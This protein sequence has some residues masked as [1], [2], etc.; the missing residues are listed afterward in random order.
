MFTSVGSWRGPF[1]PVE[2]EGR[3]FGLRVHEFRRFTELPALVDAPFEIALDIEPEDDAD[4]R[5]LRE[6]SWGIADP[7]L[8]AADLPSYQRY[9]RESMAEI[10]V[11]KEMYVATRGGWFSDRSASY[12]ASGK[13][14]LAQDTGF[15]DSLPT[16]DGLLAF[17][18]LEQ[19]VRGAE[20]ITVDLGHH[21]EAARSIA[22]EFF[23]SR[24]V[25]A[26]LLEDLDAR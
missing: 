17:S 15:G 4:L 5:A 19:A 18:T 13:P 7:S 22:E 24:K 14:V 25:L 16:G 10:A 3:S 26:E 6:R 8:V 11:A 21:S 23:D 20:E 2:Y 9:V 1:A 12:L